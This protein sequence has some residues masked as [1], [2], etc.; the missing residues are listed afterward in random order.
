MGVGGRVSE[1]GLGVA[2]VCWAGVG[3]V[4]GDGGSVSGWGWVGVRLVGGAG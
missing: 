3:P 2:S 4:G 1:W